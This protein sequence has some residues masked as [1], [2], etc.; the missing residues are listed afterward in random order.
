MFP[1][2][3]FTTLTV[4]LVVGLPVAYVLSLFLFRL[5]CAMADLELSWLRSFLLAGI[6][7]VV[8][9]GCVGGLFLLAGLLD[10]DP[11]DW[12]GPL[13]IAGLVAGLVLSWVVSL[14]LYP[15]LLPAT[16]TKGFIVATFERILGALFALLLAGVILVGL[17]VFQILRSEPQPSPGAT[18]TSLDHWAWRHSA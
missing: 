11:S 13:R 7:L 16:I 9:L 1:P 15:L 4:G 12:M 5:G 18:R 6:N 10:R 2:A 17:A 14:L 3:N 8:L